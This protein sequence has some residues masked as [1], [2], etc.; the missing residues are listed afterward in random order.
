MKNTFYLINFGL[1]ALA[2]NVFG[3]STHIEK[4]I[5]AAEADSIDLFALPFVDA[6]FAQIDEIYTTTNFSIIG[7]FTSATKIDVHGKSWILNSMSL[8]YLR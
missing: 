8:K 6:A 1:F 4:I 3:Y 7:D 2:V 5:R